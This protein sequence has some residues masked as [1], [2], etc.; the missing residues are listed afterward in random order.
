[1]ELF[2]QYGAIGLAYSGA[3]R[4]V[5]AI[6]GRSPLKQMEEGSPGFFRSPD[7]P[8][9]Y[10]LF[11]NPAQA[12]A[13]RQVATIS[14][15]VFTF[16][17]TLRGGRPATQAVVSYPLATVGFAWAAGEHRWNVYDDGSPAF[18]AAG[19]HL[20]AT[21]VIV[22]YV[23]IG[24]DGFV[25]VLG[26][27]TPYTVSVGRGRFELLRDGKVFDGVWVRG[28][29][30]QRT[31]WLDAKTHRPLPLEPGNTWIVLAPS[32]RDAAIR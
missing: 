28:S 17:P 20:T 23:H 3:N 1:V 32:G 15:Q 30:G 27:P 14:G 31:A 12:L 29:P 19:G 9:P 16:A 24:Q 11:V 22:Q 7:R 4:G 8:A 18:S 6:I 25:D 2:A 13:A 5:E 10:N 26:N 21:N